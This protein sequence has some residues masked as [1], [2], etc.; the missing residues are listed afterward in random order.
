[1]R[2]LLD[3]NVLGAIQRCL[4]EHDHDVAW[5]KALVGQEAKDPIVAAA[6]M[7]H[8]RVLVSH[9]HDMKRVHRFVSDAHTARYPRLCR[10]MFQCSQA[11]TIARLRTHMAQIQFE[12]EQ[13]RMAGKP[14]MVI[15]QKTRFIICR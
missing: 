6:A 2:F 7:E 9:D 15:I 5:S 4:E 14:L 8:D 1:V 11:E 12:Y 13:A 3:H 10:V